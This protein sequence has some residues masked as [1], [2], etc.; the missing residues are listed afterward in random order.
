MKS[1]MICANRMQ[2]INYNKYKILSCWK[3]TT[4]QERLT[5]KNGLTAKYHPV[6]NVSSF[7]I[8]ETA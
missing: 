3:N 7:I 6:S 2:L 8:E 1:T 5:D 4:A